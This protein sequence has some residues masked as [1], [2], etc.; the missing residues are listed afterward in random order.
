MQNSSNEY[1]F[2]ILWVRNIANKY[3]HIPMLISLFRSIQFEQRTTLMQH[4]K[5]YD[6]NLSMVKRNISYKLV[7]WSYLKKLVWAKNIVYVYIHFKYL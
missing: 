4:K 1:N 2:R 5:E 6:K 3:R 7:A